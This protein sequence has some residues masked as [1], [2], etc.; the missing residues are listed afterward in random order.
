MRAPLPK[1]L[2][3][4]KRLPLTRSQMMARIRSHD[5]KPE[6]LTRAAVHALGIRFRKHVA[7]LP[8]NP[9]LANR[10]QKW[11]IFVHGCFWHS[12]ESCKLAS[13]PKSNRSYW[14]PKLRRNRERDA[15]KIEALRAL[16]FRV[17]VVWECEVRHGSRL[18]AALRKFFGV[19]PAQSPTQ[20]RR[21][22]CRSQVGISNV[23][24]DVAISA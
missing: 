16:G 12:H 15:A 2:P 11:A 8:G 4:R 20:R 5:T 6:V 7:L 14:E 19:G 24:S 23:T 3:R 17:L 18:E 13:D 9:D 10:N 22:R 1:I 21:S